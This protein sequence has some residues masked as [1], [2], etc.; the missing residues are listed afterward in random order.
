MM[1]ITI[2]QIIRAA[3]AASAPALAVRRALHLPAEAAQGAVSFGSSL[4]CS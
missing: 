2:I 4:L 1:M 3:E